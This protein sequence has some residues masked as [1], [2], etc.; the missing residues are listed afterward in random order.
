MNMTRTS[1][2]YAGGYREE[3]ERNRLDLDRRSWQDTKGLIQY[4]WQAVGEN[5]C[6]TAELREP[7]RLGQEENT[8]AGCSKSPDFS[9]T[10]PRRAKTRRSAGKA[11]APRLIP[12]FTFYASRFTA[13]GSE[14]KT[15]LADF[16][17][18]LLDKWLVIRKQII[19][20]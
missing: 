9:P 3:P 5:H 7:I 4:P 18:I 16:F 12:R 20:S 10:Q 2:A 6:S 8:P 19:H 11:A 15:K 17:S 14:A 13:A 1:K